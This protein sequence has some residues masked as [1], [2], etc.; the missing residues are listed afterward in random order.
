MKGCISVIN[1]GSSSIKFS[2]FLCEEE[3]LT[4]LYDGQISGIGSSPCFEVS[5]SNGTLLES[6][7]WDQDGDGKK[8]PD[9]EALTAYIVSW[10]KKSRENLGLKLLGVGHR[11]AH[12]GDLYPEPVIV[13][14]EV[15][16]K[17]DS[18]SPLAPLHQ[19]YNLGCIRSLLSQGVD[20]PQIACFDTCFHRTNPPHTLQYALPREFRSLGL[21]RFGFHGL[22][23][24]YIAGRLQEIA[25][26]EVASRVVVAHLG[27]GA[28]MCGMI[29]GR[30]V[31]STMG[32]SALDGLVMSTRPGNVDPGILLYLIDEK[33]MDTAKLTKLLYKESGLLGLSGLSKDMRVLLGS[34]T[35]SAK[36]AIE[37]FVYRIQ[38]ELGAIV[39]TLGGLDTLVFT[40]GIGENSAEIRRRI[41]NASSWLGLKLDDSANLEGVGVISSSDSKVIVRVV[42]TD[43]ELM[44]ATHTRRLLT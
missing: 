38:R 33:G 6:F 16:E 25:P 3:R 36:E 11:I 9:Q 31:T 2:L 44:I 42:P 35:E 34:E 14:E 15:L 29:D 23:Y 19:P 13:T 40:A 39:A 1:S 24:E 41:C 10:L 32:F 26:D 21:R 7:A 8:S 17:L 30:S 5:D 12:G 22:S 43:E 4:P 27:S 20:V 37:I 18:L 28:S